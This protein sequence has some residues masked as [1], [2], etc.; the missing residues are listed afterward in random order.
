M[1]NSIKKIL[2]LIIAFTI[3]FSTLSLAASAAEHTADRPQKN[4]FSVVYDVAEAVVEK[5]KS[6]VNEIMKITVEN[7]T[8]IKFN[9]NS[10]TIDGK[11]YDMD[12]F[13]DFIRAFGIDNDV[14]KSIGY[15][16]GKENKRYGYCHT[17]TA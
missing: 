10:V 15:S 14:D 11:D 16:D 1:K 17:L 12:S 9:E 5:V 3:A 13:I 8:G 2:S 4:F 7:E 6:T